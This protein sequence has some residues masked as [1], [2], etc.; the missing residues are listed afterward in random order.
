MPTNFYVNNHDHKAQ[1]DLIHDLIIES[2]KFYGVDV[3]WIPRYK[4]SSA[5][6][7]YGED[8]LTSYRQ[9]R[10]IEMYIKNV[11]GFEGDGDFISKFGLQ[12]K[13][14][15]TFTVAVRRFEDL[16]AY[17]VDGSD[18]SS[19]FRPNEGDLIY[20]P[21]NK[22]LFHVQF[23]EHESMFYSA[24]SLPVYDLICET[25]AYNNETIET[26]IEEIDAIADKH[27]YSSTMPSGSIFD[28]TIIESTANNILDFS[29]SNP[30][31]SY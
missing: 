13:D 26:G 9:A 27:E 5:D 15:I 6:Q 30:F 3:Y 28:N 25:F 29:E 7:L 19:I 16:D 24:G 11:D 17:E 10:L 1:Q 21:L 23:V 20:F 31:G 4:S 12:I 14:Q 8:P 18:S 2:I 22:H